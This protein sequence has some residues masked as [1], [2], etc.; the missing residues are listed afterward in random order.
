MLKEEGPYRFCLVF[1]IVTLCTTGIANAATWYVSNT[2]SDV[3]DGSSPETAWQTLEAVNMADLAP[4]DAVLF[5]RGDLWRGQLLPK[6]GEENAPITYGAY[7]EGEKPRLLGSVER[8][9][10]EDWHLLQE[11][12]WVTSQPRMIGEELLP[13]AH[14][15]SENP[16]WHIYTENGAAV[17]LGK[18]E[19]TTGLHIEG[20]TPGKVG[21]DIQCYTPAFPI[22]QGGIYQL[23]L[24]ARCSVPLQLSAP[25]IMRNGPPWSAYASGNNGKSFALDNAQNTYTCY[26]VAATTA[27]DARLTFFLGETLTAETVLNL[28]SI[29]LKECDLNTILRADVGNIIFDNGAT[30]GVKVWEF[31]DL[32][33]QDEYWYDEVNHTVAVYSTANPA[34]RFD[35]IECAIREHIIDQSNRHHIVYEDLALYYGAA[36]GIGGGNTHHI[37]VRNCDFGYI[38]G[39]DQMGGDRTVRYGNGVEFWGTAHDHL[40]EGCRLWE[41]YDAALTNQSSGPVT[42]QFNITYRNNTIWNCEYSFEYWNRPEASETW[43]IRFENNTCYN[44][45]GGWGHGQRP[46]PSGRH[47]CFYTSPA[48]ARDIIIRNNIFYEA[49]G[50][51]FYAPTWPRDAIDA[52]VMDY[53]CWYQS[54][55]DLVSIDDHRY[56]M[57]VFAD[58]KREYNKEPNS[59]AA[60][61]Q[62][63]NIEARDFELKPESPCM[64][65][66]VIK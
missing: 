36:H 15:S 61:P 31:S 40:V 24:Q 62:F 14:F 54:A 2:G 7:G 12:I 52:L 27:D 6:S 46:D 10:E 43:N 5:R 63:E 38:G 32:D 28:D 30:C 33:M 16:G 45:G 29:S 64:G 18:G 66:G 26:Y 50:N 56:P 13:Q 8:N 34:T 65:M 1:V 42:P 20:V 44:A 9:A 48:H 39:G 25:V 3:S 49:L 21:S 11:N 37:T 53:N 35:D 60:A 59:L 55:G 57:A 58:Y 51:A 19:Q 4:G 22:R 47:L 17:S 41:V 23:T